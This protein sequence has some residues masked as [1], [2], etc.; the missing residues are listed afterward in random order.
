[1]RLH[2]LAILVACTLAAGTSAAAGPKPP[3]LPGARNCPIFP[4][5]NVWNKR[6]DTLP[7][8]ANSDALIKAI[9]GDSA[10]GSGCISIAPC[11]VRV[12]VAH[13][14]GCSLNDAA[15]QSY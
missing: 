9:G 13:G 10:K 15:M 2:G 8:A 7:V 11:V 14:F 5:T 4:A 6:V 12:T 1:M 3:T